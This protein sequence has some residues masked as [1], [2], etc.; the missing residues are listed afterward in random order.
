MRLQLPR[1][2]QKVANLLKHRMQSSRCG[3]AHLCRAGLGGR[4]G[5][6]SKRMLPHL[7]PR[8]VCAGGAVPA[9][10]VLPT[11]PTHPHRRRRP[12]ACRDS[13]RSVLVAM[14]R[15]LGADYLPFVC[16]VLQAGEWR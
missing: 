4:V 15:Q 6:S 3:R 14:V 5:Q 10:P 8:C 11:S 13:A 16:E 9:S 1:T 7:P 2:L 12:A